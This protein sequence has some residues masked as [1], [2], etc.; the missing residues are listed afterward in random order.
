MPEKCRSRPYL[1]FVSGRGR[2]AADSVCDAGN[3]WSYFF[4][5]SSAEFMYVMS[6]GPA[7]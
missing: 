3:H 1:C 6:M 5:G 4:L 7:A 2:T